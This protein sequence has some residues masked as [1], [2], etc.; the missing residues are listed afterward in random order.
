M[1]G[2][3]S[4]RFRRRFLKGAGL[5]AVAAAAATVS[6]V[7]WN[8]GRDTESLITDRETGA[9]IAPEAQQNVRLPDAERRQAI[10]TAARFVDTAVKRERTIE[11]FDLVS[12]ALRQGI[13][14]EQWAT[15]SIPV[16]PYPVDAARWKLD[17]Q[18]ADEI[19]LQVYVVPPAGD[20][21]RPMVF[22][23]T[24]RKGERGRWLV[25]SWVPRAN[26]GG[27]ASPP[28]GSS[29]LRADAQAADAAPG[30]V[31][32]SGA[33]SRYWL[34]APVLV[35]LGALAVPVT[36]MTRERVRTRRAVRAY[37]RETSSTRPS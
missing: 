30:P 2:W 15:G 12:P 23:L 34:L 33:L 13:T 36:L 27:S 19:G 6:I 1:R 37:E 29:S 17:Y 14:R 9:A 31:A 16:Q 35:L 4:P 24:M 28:S 18:Y 32:P 21:L 11:S 3:S 5:V 20:E 8:T 10:R 25:D 26:P 22:L 7:F